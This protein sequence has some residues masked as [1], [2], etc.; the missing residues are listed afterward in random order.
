MINKIYLAIIFSLFIAVQYAQTIDRNSEYR[1]PPSTVKIYEN[2]LNSCFLQDKLCEEIVYGA[3]LEQPTFD[4]YF[5]NFS[6]DAVNQ[7]KLFTELSK[8]IKTNLLNF[9]SKID[10]VEVHNVLYRYGYDKNVK[11]ADMDL[12]FYKNERADIVRVTCLLHE[13]RFY[14]I[15]LND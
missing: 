14:I 6:N 3:D 10:R 5:K 12:Y 2:Q 13:D 15:K 11:L 7:Y 8:D 4:F 9:K 1:L